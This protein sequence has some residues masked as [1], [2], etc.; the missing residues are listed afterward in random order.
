MEQPSSMLDAFS[1]QQ[2]L[3]CVGNGNGNGNAN[4]NAN[5]SLHARPD[6]LREPR[7]FAP[8][9]SVNRPCMVGLLSADTD[10][11]PEWVFAGELGIMQRWPAPVRVRVCACRRQV[12]DAFCV[13]V[14]AMWAEPPVSPQHPWWS[15]WAGLVTS[16]DLQA[17]GRRA[18][19]LRLGA[20]RALAPAP[21]ATT[22][23]IS[24]RTLPSA[25]S[26]PLGQ[27]R[28][29]PSGTARGAACR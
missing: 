21:Q 15:L 27:L 10:G 11:W 8:A 14:E 20:G 29:S 22:G 1:R 12:C 28:S 3:G 16:R 7:A 26:W 9:L 23:G 2:L 19:T 25:S 4:G 18:A 13:R 24:S 17:S 5:D 6:R